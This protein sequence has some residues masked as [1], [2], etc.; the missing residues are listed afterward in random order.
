MALAEAVTRL[1]DREEAV[2][3]AVWKEAARHYG[4]LELAALLVEIALINLHNRLNVATKQPA[5]Q[6]KG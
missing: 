1:S 4:E 3:D 5:G 2:P 6:W